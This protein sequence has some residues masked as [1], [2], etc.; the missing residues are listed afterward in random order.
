LSNVAN[1]NTAIDSPLA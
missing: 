1:G